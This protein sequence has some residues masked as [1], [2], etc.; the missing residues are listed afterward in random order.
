MKRALQFSFLAI[1]IAANVFSYRS[2][3]LWSFI[4][5]VCAAGLWLV[6]YLRYV[7]ATIRNNIP[8]FEPVGFLVGVFFVASG[9]WGAIKLLPTQTV[10]GS[11]LI[12][13][14]TLLPICCGL[15][16]IRNQLRLRR[17][18]N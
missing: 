12:G 2:Q 13:V 18:S 3:I 6:F 10:T 16:I 1:V 7:K 5:M 11:L 17:I 8:R 4:S 15:V 14:V 9:V